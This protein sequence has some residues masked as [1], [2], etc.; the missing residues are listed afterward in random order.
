MKLTVIEPHGFCSGVT[1]AVRAASTALAEGAPVYCLHELVHNETVV[2][3]LRARGMVFVDSLDAVPPGSRVIFSAH[4]V[5]PAVRAAAAARQLKVIDATCPFVLRVHRQVR[6]YAE[7]GIPV[8]AIGH[9][10]HVEVVGVVGEAPGHVT[11]IESPTEAARL[12]FSP[13]SK[14][15]IVVQTT[16]GEADVAA[17]LAALRARFSLAQPALSLPAIRH[18]PPATGPSP[19]YATRDRQRA[20]VA[21]VKG[22]GDAVIVLGSVTSSN[23]KRLVETAR[24]AGARLA[25]RAGSLAELDALDL[26]GVVSLGVT[27]GASTP[28]SFLRTAV[29]VLVGR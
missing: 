25:V 15:G 4:G 3:D 28:E 8:V 9:A 5:A 6:A 19:C 22:G 16:L 23:T 21:F 14:I 12:P 24:A 26:S 1:A 11:V 10:A 20:V 17:T 2:A 29:A 7:A 27:S 18:R 13:G